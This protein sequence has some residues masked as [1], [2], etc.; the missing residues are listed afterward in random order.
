MVRYLTHPVRH[1]H[2][3][4][5]AAA[6][7]GTT[8]HQDAVVGWGRGAV[9]WFLCRGRSIGRAGMRIVG[10]FGVVEVEIKAGIGLGVCVGVRLGVG[11]G[12]V[13]VSAGGGIDEGMHTVQGGAAQ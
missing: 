12:V 1:I 11:A 4:G 5:D 3:P 9:I 6:S 10:P 8:T 13:G 7:G 2:V